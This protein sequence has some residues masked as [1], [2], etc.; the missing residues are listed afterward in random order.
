MVVNSKNKPVIKVD[1]N[2]IFLKSFYFLEEEIRRINKVE[3]YKQ[4]D[5]QFLFK[6]VLDILVPKIG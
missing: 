4:K 1:I 6:K 5:F 2:A 3:H